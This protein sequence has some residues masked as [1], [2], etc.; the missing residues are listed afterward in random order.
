M[1]I[2]GYKMTELQPAI[3]SGDGKMAQNGPTWATES[4]HGPETHHLHSFVTESELDPLGV[5]RKGVWH[6][7]G[8]CWEV[9]GL[10]GRIADPGGP[11]W[12]IRISGIATSG[13]LR[14]VWGPNGVHSRVQ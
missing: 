9:F 10:F 4:S 1:V 5:D 11:S 12:A 8:S 2:L 6:C 14:W 7:F 3:G 13:R